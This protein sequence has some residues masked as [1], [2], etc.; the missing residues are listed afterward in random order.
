QT[1]ALP[2]SLFQEL[3]AQTNLVES[4]TYF[5]QGLQEKIQTDK[6]T[7]KLRG[8]KVAPNFFT[9]LGMRP[10]V[11]RTFLPDEGAK[12]TSNVIL[13][14]HGFW[15]QQFGGDPGLIGKT[16]ELD[17]RAYTVVGIMPPKM[18]F[19]LR[20][21]F[22]IPYTIPA[23]ELTRA[24]EPEAG[25]WRLIGRLRKG[26]AMKEVQTMLDTIAARWQLNIAKPN[27][28]WIFQVGRAS[29]MFYSTTLEK[30][31]WSLQAMMGALLLI[32]CA[33]VG[34]LLLSRAFSRRG[35]FGIRMAI[36]AGRLR[37]A[38]QLLVESFL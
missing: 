3:A 24:W 9:L 23:E 22:W 14:S 28:R 20:N 19:P 38:R 21:Q 4:L 15:Q 17:G 30:T 32:S 25:T 6:N 26:V 16:I 35:E 34:N 13:I 29:G 7:V 18:Q 33:N 31:L 36:G 8:A 10:L 1:C 2:I 37:I 27:Q 12:E 5:E 11:G